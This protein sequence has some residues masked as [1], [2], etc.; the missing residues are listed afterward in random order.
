M[1][2]EVE[3]GEI[4]LE[5]YPSEEPVIKQS[6][7]GGLNPVS[8]SGRIIYSLKLDQEVPGLFTVP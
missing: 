3:N 5:I 4:S 7:T 6:G 2:T 1:I 8:Q